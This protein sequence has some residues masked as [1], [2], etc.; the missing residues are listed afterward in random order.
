[1]SASNRL[2]NEKKALDEIKLSEVEKEISILLSARQMIKSMVNKSMLSIGGDA[3]N[4]LTIR[5]STMEA[6]ALFNSLLV[7]FISPIHP[8][9]GNYRSH[10]DA[11]KDICNNPHFN[12]NKSTGELRGA[13]SSFDE[14]LSHEVTFEKVWLPSA[15]NE[16]LQLK[17]SREDFLRICGD[18][19][20]HSTLRLYRTATRILS[21]LQRSNRDISLSDAF[22]GMEDFYNWFHNDVFHYHLTK[23]CEMLNN[24]AWGVQTYLADEYRRSYTVDPKK[25]LNSQLTHYSFQYPSEVKTPLGKYYYWELMNEIRAKPYIAKFKAYKYAEGRY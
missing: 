17:M 14:W 19:S 15:S 18:V 8:P 3:E 12:F 10:I 13:I 11:L 23:I 9:F 24:I 20:K 2:A 21:V 22:S 25:S 6:A 4:G 16:E 7:D 1:M 5:P